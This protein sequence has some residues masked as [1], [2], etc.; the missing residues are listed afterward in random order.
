MGP[1]DSKTSDIEY[2]E[3]K[4][5]SPEVSTAPTSMAA[6]LEQAKPSLWSRNSL[7][8]YIC[9]LVGYL[10]ST[11]NGYDGSLMYVVNPL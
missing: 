3:R 1:R 4:V 8:L 9:L 6:A 7:K 11:M 5:D 2:V 10:I